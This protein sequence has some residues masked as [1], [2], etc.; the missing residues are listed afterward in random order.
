MKWFAAAALVALLSLGVAASAQEAKPE[1]SGLSKRP[2]N[3]ASQPLGRNIRLTF[4]AKGSELPPLSLVTASTTY[5][6]EV[7]LSGAQGLTHVDI[8]GEVAAV[9]GASDRLLLTYR[10]SVAHDGVDNAVSVYGYGSA[11]VI[12]GKTTTLMD[13]AGK[14]FIV[15]VAEVK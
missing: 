4:S 3:A 7:Q 5:G 9:D 2:P 8:S 12:I 6:I 1:K 14:P 13:V 15:D 11:N 10:I